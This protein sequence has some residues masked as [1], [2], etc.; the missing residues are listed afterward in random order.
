M[1]AIILR[2]L[3]LTPLILIANIFVYEFSILDDLSTHAFINKDVLD[4][5]AE[6]QSWKMAYWHSYSMPF[7]LKALA[8]NSYLSAPKIWRW[9]ENVGR[10]VCL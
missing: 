9:D 7:L 8:L 1:L 2:K 4:V 3:L 10:G 6:K 5:N